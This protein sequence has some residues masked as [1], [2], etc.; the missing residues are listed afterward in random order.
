MEFKGRFNRGIKKLR[1]KRKSVG[2]RCAAAKSK[3]RLYFYA[4]SV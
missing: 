2:F 4:G 3:P 1:S